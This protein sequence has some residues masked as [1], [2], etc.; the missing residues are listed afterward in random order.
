MLGSIL[1][2]CL[3]VLG[4]CFLAGG[5]RFHEQGYGVRIAQQQYVQPYLIEIL[6]TPPSISLLSLCVFSISIPAAFS[7]SVKV[8]EESD[9]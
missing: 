6:L 7:S 3:L 2:N 4:M 5:F 1:S 8:L 9:M